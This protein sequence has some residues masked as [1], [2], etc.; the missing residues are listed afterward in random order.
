M[1]KTNSHMYVCR[2]LQTSSSESER[3]T[4]S[5]FGLTGLKHKI[6]DHEEYIVERNLLRRIKRNEERNKPHRKL[7]DADQPSTSHVRN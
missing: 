5:G 4:H 1:Q 7:M 3:N 2:S 6:L